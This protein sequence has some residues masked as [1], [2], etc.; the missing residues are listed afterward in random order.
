MIFHPIVKSVLS[1]LDEVDVNSSVVSIE[2]FGS[3]IKL[4]SIIIKCT[5]SLTLA[6]VDT[7]P[8]VF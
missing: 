5:L 4:V 1:H 6:A 2:L 3:F 7:D 8:S